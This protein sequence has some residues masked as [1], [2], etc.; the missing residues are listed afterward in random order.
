MKS[1]PLSPANRRFKERSDWQIF[2]GNLSRR[3]GAFLA[4]HKVKCISEHFRLN[5]LS[6][7]LAHLQKSRAL[8]L[9]NFL[10]IE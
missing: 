8:F 1:S 5:L 6:H 7:I 9:H 4:F 3:D 10:G 2:F